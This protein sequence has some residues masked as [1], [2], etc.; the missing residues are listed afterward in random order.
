MAGDQRIELLHRCG[1][2]MRPSGSSR[3]GAGLNEFL[4]MS[5]YYFAMKMRD[6]PKVV[7]ESL[8]GRHSL[9]AAY[10]E[11]VHQLDRQALS[12]A[13]TIVDLAA[14]ANLEASRRMNLSQLVGSS[15]TSDGCA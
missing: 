1:V 6:D 7:I 13:V 10:L 11:A 12:K 3:S 8:C 4:T 15:T 9:L 2:T 14:H 5:R